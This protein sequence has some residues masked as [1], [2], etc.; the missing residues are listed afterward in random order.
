MI[1]CYIQY[2]T[3]PPINTIG[4]GVRHQCEAEIADIPLGSDINRS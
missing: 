1:L 4:K 2:L 3:K